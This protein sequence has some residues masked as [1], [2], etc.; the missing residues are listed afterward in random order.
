MQPQ[1][2]IIYIE[3]QFLLVAEKPNIA[4]QHMD[5]DGN[6]KKA[7]LE[8]PPLILA[9]GLLLS[10]N[11]FIDEA[12]GCATDEHYVEEELVLLLIEEPPVSGL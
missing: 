7:M 8:A 9:F 2:I 5:T 11:Y 1:I 4:I 6:T 10:N 12:D 3:Q